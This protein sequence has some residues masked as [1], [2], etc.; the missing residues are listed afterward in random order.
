MTTAE[1]P[2]ERNSTQVGNALR[3]DPRLRRRV[4]AGSRR[5]AAPARARASVR[6]GSG[7]VHDGGERCR[8]P[9]RRPAWPGLLQ[10]RGPGL[11]QRGGELA[12]PGLG[13]G[14]LLERLGGGLGVGLC[15]GLGCLRR[16]WP[17][18]PPRPGARRAASAAAPARA[19][20][21]AA[22]CSTVSA[23]SCSATLRRWASVRARKACSRAACSA[24]ARSARVAAASA[25]R[26]GACAEA[27]CSAACRA[28]WAVRAPRSSPGWPARARG[29][30]APPPVSRARRS[31][32]GRRR[33]RLEVD[34]R[35]TGA[36]RP[37]DSRGP[38]RSR[39]A[40]SLGAAAPPAQAGPA[41]GRPSGERGG[42]A[43]AAGPGVAELV[44]SG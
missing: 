7:S 28:A 17:E 44:T 36:D 31:S 25:A 8:G 24:A 13:G 14:A 32:R 26:S 15:A 21:A 11:L 40:G 1:L 42:V 19:A 12:G 27:A 10:Q 29:A 16:G 23:A 30:G 43:H 3:L 22:T 18:R 6:A 20:E 35:G 4:P 39:S 41:G 34:L 9:A 38:P 37:V 5:P 2:G 33:G